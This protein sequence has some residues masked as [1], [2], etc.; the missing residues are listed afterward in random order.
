MSPWLVQAMW[1]LFMVKVKHHRFP[2]GCSGLW[3]FKCRQRA[4]KPD[5]PVRSNQ[6]TNFRK[7]RRGD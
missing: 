4:G 3:H 1:V 7:A 6:F 2:S 5:N